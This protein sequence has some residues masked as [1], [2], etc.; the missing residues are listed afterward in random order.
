[1]AGD[2]GGG[3][4]GVRECRR[5]DD[6]SRGSALQGGSRGV[7]RPE[8]ARDLDPGSIPRRGDDRGDLLEVGRRTRPG[9]VEVDDVEPWRA[10]HGELR[11]HGGRVVP[12]R[13]LALEIAF[14]QADDATA[15]KVDRR[16]EVERGRDLRLR[17]RA[18]TA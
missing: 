18:T 12:V 8:A 7:E 4:A 17:L 5:P 15:P 3:Q 14:D 16:E 11:S 1:V 2:E 9:A 13:G 10:R 6:D